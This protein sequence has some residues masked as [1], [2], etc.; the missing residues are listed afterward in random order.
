MNPSV[1]SWIKWFRIIQLVLRSF[2]L[3]SSIGLLVLMI[4]LRG[5]DS[6]TGWIMRIPPG[7]AILHTVYSMYHLG[8][9]PAR[10]TP[11][12]SASYMLFAAF[13]DVA[14]VAFYAFSVVVVKTRT[15]GSWTTILQNQDLVDTFSNVLFY[16]FAIGGGLYLVSLIISIYLA[17]TF[18]KITQLP[19][20]MNPLEDNLTSR[21]QHKRNKSEMSTSTTYSNEKR[22][23]MPLESKRSS[24]AA[25]ED[26]SRPPSIPFF[27]TRTGSTESFSTYQSTPP[28]SRDARMDLP[29]RQYQIGTSSQRSSFVDLK[30]ASFYDAASPP[31]RA[32][33][34]SNTELATSHRATFY[35]GPPTPPKQ[36]AYSEISLDDKEPSSTRKANRTADWY[37]RDSLPK[38]RSQSAS[39]KRGYRA[40]QSNDSDD[41]LANGHPNPLEANPPTPRIGHHPNRDSPLSEISSNRMSSDIA[42]SSRVN[43]TSIGRDLIR[44]SKHYGDLRPGTPPIMIS[45]NRQ[46][47]SGTDF[48]D[49]SHF[50][51][52]VSGKVAEEGRGGNGSEGWRTRFRKISGKRPG[53]S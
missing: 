50:R 14:I 42:D 27:H 35:G 31:K 40:V 36:G 18:R 11:A 17:V 39:P 22:L 9:E 30:R 49:K 33:Y 21:T 34:N 26:L 44:T 1:K 48:V 6:G 15:P 10:R 41:D 29:S 20:D 52:E 23:S 4:L 2:E 13:F 37:T 24:G 28:P 5:M 32:S 7:V 16:G 19:P 43:E 3:I 12:S 45:G 25:Y 46:V 47:S 53:G 38:T 51:R 8:R